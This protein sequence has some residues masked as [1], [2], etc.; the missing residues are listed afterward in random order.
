MLVPFGRQLFDVTLNASNVDATIVR[1]PLGSAGSAARGKGRLDPQRDLL[2][3]GKASG[4]PF[5]AHLPISL[6]AGL[7]ARA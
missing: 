6:A 1:Q 7:R 5:D 4:L 3:R 2:P